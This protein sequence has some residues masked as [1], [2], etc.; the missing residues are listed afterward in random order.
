MLKDGSKVKRSSGEVS[1]SSLACG[2]ILDQNGKRAKAKT[3]DRG[4]GNKLSAELSQELAK[5][6]EKMWLK[7]QED[8]RNAKAMNMN[9]KK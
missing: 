7:A 4:S 9:L 1:I 5:Q 8:N 6:F 2:L 3:F